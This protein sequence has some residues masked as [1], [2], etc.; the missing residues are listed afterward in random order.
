[1]R[2]VIL[3]SVYLVIGLVISQFLPFFF[4]VDLFKKADLILGVFTMICL[5][6]IMIQVGREF[7]ID[8][9]KIGSYGVD[10]LA[11]A[12][13]AA[14]PWLL[15]SVYFIFM[16]LPENSWKSFDSWKDVLVIS[17]FAAPTS[18]GVLF[19]MLAAAGLS[20]T[21]VYGKVKIL[22]IFDDLDTVLLMIPLKIMIVGFAWQMGGIILAMAVF[23]TIAWVFLHKT[24]L[25]YS[26]QWILI[27]S[28]VIV[29]GSELIYHLS[30]IF[31]PDVPVHIEVLL[32]AFVLGCILPG[33]KH[34]NDKE[35]SEQ[36]VSHYISSIFM[37]LVGLSMP[38]ILAGADGEF[39]MRWGT[40]IFHVLMITLL[41][42]IGKMLVILFYRKEASLYERFAISVGMFPRGEV[43]AG[44]LVLAL[45]YSIDKSL[46]YISMLS[47]A[48]NLI[49]TGFF[50]VVVKLLI[51]KSLSKKS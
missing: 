5:S 11:A 36:K 28:T 34:K 39:S 41:S 21:W 37:V 13:A 30:R 16:V 2:K 40:L 6:Y 9:N 3:Y 18:A 49:L 12:T 23:L 29:A 43:G 8:K 25:P 48:L 38:S 20:G 27:Y 51:D 10:Y 42:N 15:C 17:R 50:I 19:A 32:P 14:L 45:S 1:M 4:S 47:L 35:D 31:D 7:H 44:I 22:A 33:H 26:W 24:K 46:V